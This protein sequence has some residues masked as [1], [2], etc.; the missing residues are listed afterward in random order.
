MSQLEKVCKALGADYSIQSIDWEDVIYRDF[1]NGYDVEIS[2]LGF[3]NKA[4]IYLWE[5]KCRIVDTRYNVELARIHEVVEE[6]YREG[7]KWIE[8][9]QKLQ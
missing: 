9:K 4:T 3:R 6:L 1:H 7:N 8:K 2:G 5:N